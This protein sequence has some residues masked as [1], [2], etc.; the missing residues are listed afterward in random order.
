MTGVGLLLFVPL[1]NMGNNHAKCSRD[2]GYYT[3]YAAKSIFG[4]ERNR[5]GERDT[6]MAAIGVHDP[7]NGQ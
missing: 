2:R 6:V 4:V 3:F 5:A 1:M 7:F